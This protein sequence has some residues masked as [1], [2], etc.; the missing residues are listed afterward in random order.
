MGMWLRKKLQKVQKL[1]RE[2]KSKKPSTQVHINY[3]NDFSMLLPIEF[4]GKPSAKGKNSDISL[5]ME[6]ELKWKK[7]LLQRF[8]KQNYSVTGT[9]DEHSPI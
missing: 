7:G 2:S 5:K 3:L 1:F 6:A 8:K 9:A 4:L